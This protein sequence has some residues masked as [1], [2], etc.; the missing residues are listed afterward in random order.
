MVVVSGVESVEAH[1]ESVLGRLVRI[2]PVGEVERVSFSAAFGLRIEGVRATR[3]GIG[4]IEIPRSSIAAKIVLNA[5][6]VKVLYD[7]SLQ[8]GI[9]G[10]VSLADGL[11]LLFVLDLAYRWTTTRPE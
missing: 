11:N 9:G 2:E 1:P 8:C 10:L 4:R 7:E 3:L 6:P 5:R